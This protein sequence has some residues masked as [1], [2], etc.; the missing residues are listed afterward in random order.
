M[1]SSTLDMYGNWQ[2]VAVCN[3]HDFRTLA[4]LCFANFGAPFLA[5]A[6]LPS[7]KASR[8]SKTPL[9]LRS[10][11]PQEHVSSLQIEPI[12]ETCDGRSGSK[13]SALFSKKLSNQTAYI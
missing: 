13:D 9:A 3:G 11:E 12:V 1:W 7:I 5:G 10:K 4:A 8:T 6:K 2:T